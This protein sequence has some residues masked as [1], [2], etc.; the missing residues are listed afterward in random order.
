MPVKSKKS[1]R[2]VAVQ[3]QQK[4]THAFFMLDAE[5]KLTFFDDTLS[6]FLSPSSNPVLG[7]RMSELLGKNNAG[8]FE[9]AFADV[10]GSKTAAEFYM[11][12][13]KGQTAQK[14]VMVNLSPYIRNGKP[15]G[16]V[17]IVRWAFD[18]KTETSEN[19]FEYLAESLTVGVL[20]VVDG[21]NFWLN[22][23][24][25][26]IFGYSREEMIGKGMDLI[27]LP[28][29][30][31]TLMT[32][33]KKRLAD[34]DVPDEYETLGKR[35]DG[36]TVFVN[37]KAKKINYDTKDAILLL[38]DDI[39]ARKRT[40]EALIKSEKLHRTLAETA[41]DV[42]CIFNRDL[43]LEYV[44]NYTAGFFKCCPNDMIGRDWDQFVGQQKSSKLKE[45]IDLIFKTGESIYLESE[46]QTP[47]GDY[48]MGA[49]LVPIL[50]EEDS[51]KN[52]LM[53]GR[54]ISERKKM[55][56]ALRE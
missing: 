51:V 49:W 17:G 8:V 36:S 46:I 38:I 48:W 15:Y 1:S 42:I 6:A 22:H 52:V 31:P 16:A 53:V 43:S 5:Q 40:E 24:F 9:V 32:R 29:D 2:K 35:K 34:L 19:K 14:S 3:Q 18:Q 54:N 28:E 13:G 7:K 12:A 23:A 30:L 55:E 11:Q 56:Q 4:A 39:T 47:K 10:Q 44:N 21:K 37:V 45:K 33:M 27:I 50:D 20:I 26:D 25:A 41:R